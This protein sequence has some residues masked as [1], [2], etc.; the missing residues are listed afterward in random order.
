MSSSPPTPNPGRRRFSLKRFLVLVVPCLVVLGGV[1]FYFLHDA[2]RTTE[3]DYV[4]L[5]A[6]YSLRFGPRAILDEKRYV[7]SDGDLVA[8]VPKDRA[9]LVDPKELVFTGIVFD[10]PEKAQATW[11]PLTDYLSEQVGRPVRFDT[12]LTG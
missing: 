9:A 2:D 3:A 4:R 7:D 5:V 6:D 8:D 1:G 12:T 10:A 11:K